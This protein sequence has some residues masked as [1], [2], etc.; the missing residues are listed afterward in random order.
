MSSRRTIGWKFRRWPSRTLLHAFWAR[1]GVSYCG[2]VDTRVGYW[3]EPV[4]GGDYEVN[5]DS[6]SLCR[7][8]SQR[9]LEQQR[10]LRVAEELNAEARRSS[11]SA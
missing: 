6:R 8:C 4:A 2:K 1:G 5:L 10:A 11:C 9:V 7:R 3:A